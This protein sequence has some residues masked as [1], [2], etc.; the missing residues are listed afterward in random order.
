MKSVLKTEEGRCCDSAS[1]SLMNDSL[2]SVCHQMS[3]FLERAKPRP[4]IRCSGPYTLI[5]TPSCF[6]KQ[7]KMTS[8]TCK[9]Q[10]KAHNNSANK[11]IACGVEMCS[12]SCSTGLQKNTILS[13]RVFSCGQALFLM[14]V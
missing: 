4:L 1:V 2:M 13:T 14:L 7:G 9:I 8:L 12:C 5:W 6:S 11:I 3:L 10:R